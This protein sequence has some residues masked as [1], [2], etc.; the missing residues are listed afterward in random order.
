MKH[1]R[2]LV[3]ALLSASWDDGFGSYS[4]DSLLGEETAATRRDIATNI[5][6]TLLRAQRDTENARTKQDSGTGAK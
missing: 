1:R 5:V 3:D 2:D 6:D 4:L